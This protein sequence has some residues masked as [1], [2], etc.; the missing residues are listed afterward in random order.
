MLALVSTPLVAQAPPA[1][2][3]DF[4]GVL[5]GNYQWRTD[6]A[7]R[8]TTGGEPANRFDIGRAYLN[9]RMPAGERG[10]I[11]ITTDI[12]QQT[13]AA[14]SYYSGWAVRL[15]Y[16]YFQYDFTRNLAGIQG[17]AAAGR[18]GMMQTAVIEY[19][20]TFWLRW[21]GNSP[22]ELN[23]FFSSADVGAGA[24]V[25]FPNRYGEVYATIVN[26]NGYGAAETD[27][28][29]DF[30]G[31]ATFTP[32]ANDSGFFRTV[33]FTPWY[34]KGMMASGFVLGGPGQVGPVSDG[35]TRD[36]RGV[37]L[38]IRDRRLTGG[39]D[40]AQRIEGVESGLNTL[41]SPRA[42]RDR[43]GTLFAA[44]AFARPLEI[45][46]LSTR[47][48]LTV[49]GRY[50]EFDVDDTNAAM[51]QLAWAGL[52]WD[53]NSRT[54]FSVDFQELRVKGGSTTVPTNTLFFHWTTAF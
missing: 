43:T 49:F 53:L 1:P 52:M 3:L 23:G 54:T 13:G 20:E 5:F 35:L 33:S 51:N 48:R 45:L 26:G 29:K 38:G 15:K 17:L 2:V 31:R 21:L 4:S 40:Y 32:F 41:V 50:D 14:A 27:R 37:F 22:V 9:F 28:F 47:S 18:I 36:R 7:A 39:I 10:N 42:V 16:G 34:S 25:G 12:Y 44:F 8:A 30:A 6:A 24:L 46:R 19:M 11:R